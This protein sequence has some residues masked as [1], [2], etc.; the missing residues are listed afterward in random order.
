MLSRLK[1][2]I[3]P[4][5]NQIL[6]ALPNHI[7]Q[8][9]T[10]TFLDPSMGGGQFLVEIQKRLR[11]AGHGDENIS[12]RIY[13]CEKNKL[14][15]NYAKNNKKLVSKN[16]Y[17]S[18]F[19]SQ[20]WGDMKFD[21]IIGNPPYQSEKR[22][23]TQPLWPLFVHKAYSLLEDSGYLGMITPN[24][25]CGHTTNV[26]KGDIH[27]YQ[28]IFKNKLVACDI[29]KCSK[30]FPGVGS[31]ENSFS[32][33][34]IANAGSHK[35]KAYTLDHE[36]EVN[37]EWFDQ[38]P[39]KSLNKITSEIIRK[40]KTADSFEFKQVSTG[41][42]NSGNC[43]IVISMA[44]RM[45]YS[46]LPIYLDK[47]V[48][49]APTSKSTVSQRKFPVAT[50][51]NIDSVFRSKVFQFLYAI[52]WNHDNFSTKF[53]NRLPFIDVNKKWSDTEIYSL[54]NLTKQEIDYIES[55]VT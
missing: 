52:Y 5:V 30:Y 40:C 16:L 27:L 23:G 9:S 26:I 46:R 17:I 12:S 10:T 6:D 51:E 20:D 11:E 44:Q 1:F 54:F 42:E 41:Y 43:A 34:V 29:Q 21:V 8:S 33:F 53:Y 19:L 3:T 25:W 4:L 45:H 14:R 38:L 50:Q 24:K 28:N 13:G 37:A 39:L 18:D 49:T 47:G 7:W 22:T 32:W 31:Y 36:F 48:T 35:F 15:V 55:Y 2:E